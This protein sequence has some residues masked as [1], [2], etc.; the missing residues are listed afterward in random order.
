MAQFDCAKN[1]AM[2]RYSSALQFPMLC[3]VSS[4]ARMTNG[5]K[6]QEENH[7]DRD[8]HFKNV[9]I[10]SVSTI[11]LILCDGVSGSGR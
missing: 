7:D 9:P 2:M 10:L 11:S 8:C 5:E 6:T 4:K 3:V 1:F